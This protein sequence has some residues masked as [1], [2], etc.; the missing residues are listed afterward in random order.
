MNIL[1]YVHL[2]NIYGSTGHGRYTRQITEHLAESSEDRLHILAD[3]LDHRKVVHKVGAPWTDFP[4]HFFDKETSSQQARWALTDKPAAEHYWPEAEVVYCTG[5]SYVPT[6]KARLVVTLHD[7]AL[8][9][10]EAHRPSW[11]LFKQKLKKRFLCHLLSRKADIV[12]T[13]SNF[14]A[15]RLAHF[16][17]GIAPRL[18]VVH[19]AAPPRF[20]L[21]VSDE[22]ESFI[23][24]N[25]LTEQPF[26]L[27]PGGLNHRKNAAMV[28]KA[29]PLIR[30]LHPEL[31]LVIAGHSDPLYIPKADGLGE[32]VKRTGFVS[33]EALCSL[34]HAAEVVWFPSLYE[35]FGIPVLEAMACGTPV[36]TSNS[37]SIPEVAGDAA[38]LVPPTSIS[39]HIEALDA[40]L[41]DSRQQNL[42]ALRGKSRA[43]LFTWARCVAELRQH[44]SCMI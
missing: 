30:Q 18:R 16:F 43:G 34:Y 11:W 26:I 21:P 28:L 37:T 42:L 22:G 17:P 6:R 32:S 5:E 15:E 33:D 27:L 8:F 20:F 19:L 10:P 13:I 24:E 29:W 3:P 35:G 4:Y 9:E 36:V 38:V 40:L 2:R 14:S 23:R 39:E 1:A 7:A 25:G 31:K 44:F 12:H 41:N